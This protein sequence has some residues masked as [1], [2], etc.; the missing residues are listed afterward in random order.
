MDK[1][2]PG[3]RRAS[4]MAA[5]SAGQLRFLTEPEPPR[6]VALPV[7]PGIRRVVARNP[8][9]MTY[10]GT[11]TY[12]AET[13]EGAFVL[14]P[15]PDD[16]AH[17]ADVLAAAGRTV[18][19]IVLSHSHP[20][21]LGALAALRR[22]TGAPSYAWHAPAAAGFTPDVPLH[23]GDQAGPW[24][25]L[26]TPGHASDHICLAGPDGVLFSADHVM[27]WSSTVIGLPGGGMADYMASLRRLLSREARLYLPGHGP[28]LP[29]PNGFVQG[30]LAHRQA[31]EAAIIRMLTDRPQSS[32]VLMQRLYLSLDPGLKRAAERNVVAHLLKLGADGAAAETEGG[33]V[34][35]RPPAQPP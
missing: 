33:W 23:D 14:D 34:R 5:E 10:W 29:S 4:G 16:P 15:G 21:H 30:L 11:N 19:G 25:V 1:D 13:A 7:A 18:R 6:G 2:A 9:A 27:S 32:A 12:L 35:N 20:D 24:Q 8:S 26:H 17:V 3:P 31:R 28:P 22:E